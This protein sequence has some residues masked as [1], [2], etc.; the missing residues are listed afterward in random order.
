MVKEQK[1]RIAELIKLAELG[2]AE[3]D[4]RRSVQLELLKQDKSKLLSQLTAQE[5]VIQGLRSERRIWGQ[6]LA[7]QGA[8]LAQDR[9][10]LEAKI[11]VLATEL[12]TQKKLNERDNDALRIKAKIVDDQTET[13]RKLKQGLLDR[14][15][16]IRRLREE[17][18]QA[19]K[20]FQEQLE[21]EAGPVRDLRE[22][23]ELLTHRKEELKQ[24]LEDKELEL[25]EVKSAYSAMNS[26]WKTKADLLTRLEEQVKRMKEGFDAKEK[27]LL[28]ERD[29]SVQ[30]HKAV[31]EK[32]RT[33]DDAFRRQLESVQA[34]HQAELFHLANEKQKQIEQANQKVCL[35]EEE[36]RLLLEE[37][38]STKKA[39]EEKMARLTSVL[40][41]F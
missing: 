30:A 10:R 28:E 11:E 27:A 19:E 41:D 13:I 1:S 17:S 29:R 18:L 23:V 33:V 22:R 16:Q 35:V 40:K 14:D 7:Q 8:S 20:R 24:Q 37:T 4:R 39:M 15:E 25:E 6:E 26:K 38:Q 31:M 34:T 36:M 21:E 2:N 5:S 3:E 12:E 32:L 9:G